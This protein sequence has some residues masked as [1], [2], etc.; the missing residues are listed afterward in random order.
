VAVDVTIRLLGDPLPFQRLIC[1]ALETP[2][3]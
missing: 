1:S 2:G 3:A